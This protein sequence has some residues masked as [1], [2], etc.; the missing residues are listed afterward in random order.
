MVIGEDA[1]IEYDGN[2]N[3]T[4]TPL[5]PVFDNDPPTDVAGG[6]DNVLWVGTASGKL[7]SFDGTTW[8]LRYT[9][10]KPIK[11]L[12]VINCVVYVVLGNDTS[13]W[14]FDPSDDTATEFPTEDEVEVIFP[15]EGE[16]VTGGEGGV[17]VHV[18]LPGTF[19]TEVLSAD[20]LM[21]EV[22][23]SP[24]VSAN[25]DVDT[26]QCFVRVEPSSAA[27]AQR[28]SYQLALPRAWVRL[29]ETARA[30]RV[31]IKPPPGVKCSSVNVALTAAP[32]E[33][34]T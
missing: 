14:A 30:V 2:N 7:Y 18:P 16:V 22:L 8:T 9:F 27:P 21:G 26:V 32:E 15:W 28:G 31:A 12:V 23:I 19:I 34:A 4:V 10:A 24:V 3:P 13:Y 11:S 29:S 6:C 1:I 20:A 33:G 17:S 25:V 5:P